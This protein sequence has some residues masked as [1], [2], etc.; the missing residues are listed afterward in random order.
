MDDLDLQLLRRF[1]K[2]EI[3]PPDGMQARI[4]ER[5]WQSILDEERAKAGAGSRR[6]R[7]WGSF[8]RPALASGTAVL[9]VVGVAMVSDGGS[10]A[11]NSGVSSGSVV[12]AGSN[13]L[14]S[15]A[16]SLFGSNAESTAP[17]VGRIDLGHDDS[18]AASLA[19]GPTHQASGALDAKSTAMVD[20]TSRDPDQLLDD[21]RSS[22]HEAGFADAHDTLAFRAALQWIVDP[23]VPT[24][25]RSAMLRALAG[26]HGIDEASMGTDVIGRSGV[27]LGHLDDASGI[28]TQA[29]LDAD[30]GTLRELRSYTTSY[31]DPACPPGTFTEHA[32]YADDGS[33]VDPSSQP[34]VDWP[35]VVAMCDHGTP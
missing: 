31:L 9:L 5:I 13:P 34:F 33:T 14:D 28:R 16:A 24:D 11:T 23:Q 27:V 35:T 15:T 18:N 19:S 29:V 6:R 17:I 20:A 10:T 22:V 26:M 30:A 21:V 7:R 4:E 1:R 3:E 2:D 8:L 32:L 25:L 12:R